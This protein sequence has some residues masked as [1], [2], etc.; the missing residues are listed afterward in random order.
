MTDNFCS[1]YNAIKF[2]MIESKVL[3]QTS[4]LAQPNFFLTQNTF[5]SKTQKQ[6]K[7]NIQ[8]VSTNHHLSISPHTHDSICDSFTQP[9]LSSPSISYI[10]PF[11][12]PILL[13]TLI[14]SLSLLNPTD[15]YK[16]GQRGSE[17]PPDLPRPR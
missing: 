12:Q 15:R 8:R 4:M 10:K 1:V 6:V 3:I 2:Q 7:N 5:H 17:G 14:L 11:I 13:L 9:L 16:D